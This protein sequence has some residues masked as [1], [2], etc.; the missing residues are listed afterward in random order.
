MLKHFCRLT[1]T[2]MLNMEL[3]SLIL[4]QE[5]EED[6]LE[7]IKRVSGYRVDCKEKDGRIVQLTNEV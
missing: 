2:V 7:G 3:C 4:M 1:K 5:M 6:C